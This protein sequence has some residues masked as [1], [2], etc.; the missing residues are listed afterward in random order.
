MSE[1]SP[2]GRQGA[3]DGGSF[4]LWD[5]VEWVAVAVTNHHL[6]RE[7]L[8]VCGTVACQKRALVSGRLLLTH[9]G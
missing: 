7:Q 1:C 6:D 4:G 5:G 9:W 2:A 3:V 8:V